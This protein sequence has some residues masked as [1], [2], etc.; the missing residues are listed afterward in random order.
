MQGSSTLDN[1]KTMTSYCTSIYIL[2]G[3]ESSSSQKF[4]PSRNIKWS[5]ETVKAKKRRDFWLDIFDLLHPEKYSKI[6]DMY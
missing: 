6:Q 4:V 1:A 3:N 2:Y 5:N